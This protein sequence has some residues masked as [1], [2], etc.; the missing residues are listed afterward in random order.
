M[1][2][3]VDLGFLKGNRLKIVTVLAPEVDGLTLE[4]LARGCLV[5]DLKAL[6]QTCH[7]MEQNWGLLVS[8]KSAHGRLIW[9]LPGQLALVAGRLCLGPQGGENPRTASRASAA[10]EGKSPSCEA[11]ESGE[12][13]K[14]RV[15]G[16]SIN[17]ERGKS[18]FCENGESGESEKF[19]VGGNS[20][21]PERGKAPTCEDDGLLRNPEKLRE[22]VGVRGS[23][24][25]K[26]PFYHG[27]RPQKGENPRSGRRMFEADSLRSDSFKTDSRKDL[28]NKDSIQP[29][30]GAKTGSNFS[31]EQE[32]R[33]LLRRANLLFGKPVKWH[34]SFSE[35]QPWELLGWLAQA[36]QAYQRG[37][38]DRPWGLVYRGLLG[39]L[40]QKEPDRAYRAEPWLSLPDEYLQAC[41]LVD[42]LSAEPEQESL[43]WD[44]PPAYSP[45]SDPQA[46]DEI[47]EEDEPLMSPPRWAQDGR[48]VKAWQVVLQ[49]LESSTSR[50]AFQTWMRD[51]WP[52][53][54][55]EPSGLLSVAARD[56]EAVEW[57]DDR[58][59][60]TTRRM[61]CGILNREVQVRF[62]LA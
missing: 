8:R 55:D 51:T 52:V 2:E 36:W 1:S 26:I 18:P 16:N 61:L 56:Q 32:N 47:S 3:Y 24:R 27:K 43:E 22:E 17:P 41:G 20:H 39:E 19:R 33:L 37:K 50:A 49:D 12:S 57:L 58:L 11:D 46:E 15:G 28:I 62:V 35:K 4:A 53:G 9:S 29:D 10:G 6:R 48:I 13:E 59:A 38:S 42:D 60:S 34:E 14:F 30:L 54:W 25:G 40:R 44:E 31:L 45:Q 5:R 21:I 7:D 23:D